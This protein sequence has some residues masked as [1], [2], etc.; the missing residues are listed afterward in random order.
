MF[1]LLLVI[2]ITKINSRV[3][4]NYDNDIGDHKIKLPCDHIFEMI[5][6]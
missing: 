3:I 4:L 5:I 2:L 6:Y 1:A